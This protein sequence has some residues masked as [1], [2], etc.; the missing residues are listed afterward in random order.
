MPL[1]CFQRG[2]KPFFPQCIFFLL[3]MSFVG[4][5][6][7]GQRG[8]R[9]Y[10]ELKVYQLKTKAQEERIDNYLQKAYL[11]ALHRAGIKNVGV[12]KPITPQDSLLQVYVFIP[13]RS[14]QQL[15]SVQQTLQKDKQYLADGKDYLDAAHNN[16]PY[17]RM[18]GMLM[19]AFEGMPQ[20][21]VPKLTGPR[22]ERVYELRSYESATE[23]YFENKVEMFNQGEIT[24]FERLGFNAMFYAKV[25][26]GSNMPNLVY[27]TCFD[28]KAS[29]D[30]HWKA[31]SADAEWKKMSGMTR[32]QNNVSKINIYFLYP[33]A[34][35][36]F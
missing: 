15:T 27:M 35:S 14:L 6:A 11:P 31:F 21:S 36:D 17:E 25:I 26:S 23:R 2:V 32:Y 29:R 5:N 7:F 28:N 19:E 13:L 3:L 34:Y 20:P 4:S 33:T 30:A 12:F 9:S 1:P 22:E 18:Q 24:L 8:V 16:A 10:Y